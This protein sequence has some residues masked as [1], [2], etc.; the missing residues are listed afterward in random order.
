MF[1]ELDQFFSDPEF[2]VAIVIAKNT[3][4]TNHSGIL[5]K[6]GNNASF[7]HLA[8]HLNLEQESYPDFLTNIHLSLKRWVK[9]NSL[10]A[11]PV[12]AE[13][14]VPAIIKKLQLIY[15]KNMGSIPYSLKF[16]DT[17]FTDDGDLKLGEGEM[18]LTCATFIASFFSSVGIPLVDLDSWISREEDLEW[19]AFIIGVMNKTGVP[20]NH[21]AN[22]T[23]EAINY[24][25]KPE[26]IAVASSKEVTDLPATFGFCTVEGAIYN[27]L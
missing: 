13:Y 17:Q 2:S 12:V 5:T 14:R 11:D 21:I 18:G 7:F 6:E 22:V 23:K 4:G 15:S 16:Q 27:T 24:R 20:I 10:T 19:K 1:L 3:L 26:E 8:W 25:V 9:F